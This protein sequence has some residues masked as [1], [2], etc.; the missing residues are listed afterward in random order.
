M[1]GRF[2]GRW[3]TGTRRP[4]GHA[5]SALVR[6]T[7]RTRGSHPETSTPTPDLNRPSPPG[8]CWG[9]TMRPS[10]AMATTPPARRTAPAPSRVAVGLWRTPAGIAPRSLSA[11]PASHRSKKSALPSAHGHIPHLRQATAPTGKSSMLR[12]L[13]TTRV[14]RPGVDR[15]SVRDTSTLATNGRAARTRSV[16]TVRAARCE[17][18]ADADA[19]FTSGHRCRAR[20]R[21]TARRS[22]GPRRQSRSRSTWLAQ[23]SVP[24][25]WYQSRRRAAAQRVSSC[26]EDSWSLRSTADTC[27]S[28]VLIEMNSSEAT[29]R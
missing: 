17:S 28:T 14:P 20:P 27:V 23:E 8:R 7:R 21:R 24:E 4:G 2:H 10:G 11:R 15:A 25:P 6:A 29:S 19:G 9:T 16:K 1:V 22:P 26:R 12:W 3:S 5:T 13:S 18:G